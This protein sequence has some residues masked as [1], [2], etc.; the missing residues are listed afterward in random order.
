M[1]FTRPFVARALSSAYH[2]SVTPME[3]LSPAFPIVARKLAPPSAAPFPKA[4]S[5]PNVV[6]ASWVISA[7]VASISTCLGKTST[8]LSMSSMIW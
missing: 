3:Y 6:L 8:R 1:M 5:I 2:L 7:M 4:Q